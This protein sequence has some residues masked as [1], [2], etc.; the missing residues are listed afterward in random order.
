MLLQRNL[1][2]F[3]QSILMHLDPSVLLQQVM[4]VVYHGLVTTW[5]LEC[6]YDCCWSATSQLLDGF[7]RTVVWFLFA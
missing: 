2:T 3:L 4:V 5:I 7:L 6:L 1:S